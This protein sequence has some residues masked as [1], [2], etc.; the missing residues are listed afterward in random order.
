MIS[1]FKFE[2]KVDREPERKV[3]VNI[4]W[5]KTAN[6][7]IIRKKQLYHE[8]VFKVVTLKGALFGSKRQALQ[9]GDKDL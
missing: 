1:C 4:N 5:E 2:N 7:W 8:G 9:N 6:E 3:Y